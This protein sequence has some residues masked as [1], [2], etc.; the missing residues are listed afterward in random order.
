MRDKRIHI[1][2][3][4]PCFLTTAHS[5]ADIDEIIRAFR[6]SIVE[7]QEAGFLTAP[8]A[9]IEET[10]ADAPLTEPQ[11]EILLAARLGDDASCSY[12][13]SFSV[14]LRG[15]LDVDAL[16]AAVN[17]LI[18]R[19]EALRASVDAES[20]TLRFHPEL[21][22]DIPLRDLS[23]LTPA[24]REDEL[25]H[26]LAEDA[27]T[28]FDLAGG[29]LVRAKLVRM[30][31]SHH[32]LVVTSHHIVC[33][34]WSTNVLLDELSH[35]YSKK[36]AGLAPELAPPVRFSKYAQELAR[37]QSS[38]NNSQ[39]EAYWL[40]QYRDLPA[41]LDLPVDRPR[42]AVRSYAGTTFRTRIDADAY[43]KIKQ[44]GAK[45]GCTLFATLLAGFQ[46]LLHRLSR[47]DD[48][49]VGIPAAGQSLLDDGALVGHCVNFLPLR[50]QFRDDLKFAELLAKAKTTLLDAYEHQSYTY[51]TLVRK[52]GVRRDPS[53]LPLMEVQFNLER[54]GAG[55]DFAGLKAH[56]EPNP[57][58][59]VNFDL[60][61][62]VVESD[63]GLT[64]N[65]DYNTDLFDQ[66]TIGRWLTHYEQL[67]LGA[68]SDPEQM[69]A[70]LP[71]MS[72]AET[73][74]LLE[75]W[76]PRPTIATPHD[77]IDAL[78]ARQA[79][80]TPDAVAVTCADVRLTYRD[81]EARA[82]QLARFMQTRGVT[83]GSLVAV[84]MERS[85][86]MIVA[87]LAILKAGAG[88]LPI[89]SSYPLERLAMIFADARPV[90]L[91]TQ[92]RLVESLPKTEAT[93]VCV[94][95]DWPAIA[96]EDAG[97]LDRT[98]R[99]ETNA[100]VIYTSG[101]TGKPKGV[102]VSHHNVV[103]LLEATAPWF[104]FGPTDVWTLFHSYAFDFSV[105]EMWGC[106]LTGG[107]LV[108][109]PYL[110]TRSPQEFYD[111]IA[112][113]QVTVLNQTPAAFYQLIQVEESGYVKPLA[114]RH[115]IFG[116]EAL[117]LVNLAPWFA[118]HGDTAPRLVNMY[119]I[120]ETTVH[121]TYRPLT[122]ADAS[123]PRSVIGAPIPDL[124]LYLLDHKQRPVPPGVVGE[125]HVGGAG[126]AKGYLNRD[127]LT[128][129]RF[130][131]DPFAGSG[132]RMYR[133]GDLARFLNN[134]DVEYLGRG[135]SQVKVHG[136]RIELGEI[137]AALAQHPSLRQA[138]VMAR[139]D[140]PGEQKL[141][142]YVVA[143]PGTQAAGSALKEFLEAKLPAHMI[144]Y[145]YVP[146][147]ALPLTVNGKVDWKQLPAPDLGAAQAREYVAPRTPQEAIL[148]DIL[149]EVLRLKRVGVT[150]NLFELGADSLHVFQITSRAVK[151]GLAITPRM[152]LQQ[153]TIAGVLAAA[154]E[155][156]APARPAATT[157]SRV[158]RQR[159]RVEATGS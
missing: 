111:L 65:C 5:E 137:E 21:K 114:L 50:M 76:N 51:G 84:S 71:L 157:I 64:I 60:F 147:D 94:D 108:I 91:L 132:A 102:M 41:P 23:G 66:E 3:G 7:M 126:V 121:V 33:D 20:M 74:A 44:L 16:R 125:I 73:A 58:G 25:Q 146:M 103:R 141:V 59:A 19:H 36:V 38:A 22:L 106:L 105:W 109:V 133:S 30:E 78:F 151:A 35:I 75:R 156:P 56:A 29:P 148:A 86:E 113:E 144:P 18:A 32:M 62:N 130:L 138:A 54:I 96:R 63:E 14:H 142:A 48:V 45:K 122:A 2:E 40:G 46:A 88:Y 6:E 95:R 81:L 104:G 28:A 99:P 27:H 57:K 12:N 8:T 4:F 49:V 98:G 134:G 100:Y 128:A 47:Q 155:A 129:E 72:A 13:E 116:G 79:A 140:G 120:T 136:F 154:A 43:R 82:N 17:A 39:V 119:G 131:T 68:A 123:E 61:F 67:L 143:K 145:A 89:D 77:T 118:R 101:S 83:P 11:R 15:A 90:M 153:R 107:R 24:A 10:A 69:I 80:S 26:M 85:V 53:R 127:A 1:R 152:V 117:N 55:A 110:V 52:L 149:A 92:E 93:V 31:A 70:D 34:G 124:R 37:D 115:V 135:D 42:P 112:A 158:T 150:D 159:Y 97:P 9:S 139:R 87:F